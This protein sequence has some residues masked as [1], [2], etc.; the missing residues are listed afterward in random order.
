MD[1]YMKNMGRSLPKVKHKKKI[2][3]RKKHASP[4]LDERPDW[5]NR[6]YVDSI[7]NFTNVHTHYKVRNNFFK[8]NLAI[9]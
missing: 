2:V 7:P 5:N 1:A 9:F 4:S 3:K 6:F 8:I